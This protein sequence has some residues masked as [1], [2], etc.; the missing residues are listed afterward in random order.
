MDPAIL[1]LAVLC[2]REDVLVVFSSHDSD[3]P[4]YFL[5]RGTGFSESAMNF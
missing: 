2:F 5:C 3:S 4:R 1:L